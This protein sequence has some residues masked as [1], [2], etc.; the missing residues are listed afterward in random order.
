V[1][2]EKKTKAQLIEELSELRLRLK[3]RGG[4][5]GRKEK[6]PKG[7]PAP[8]GDGI[9]RI[10]QG[11]RIFDELESI[12]GQ[13]LGLQ[14]RPLVRALDRLQT[15]LKKMDQDLK[16][17]QLSEEKYSEIF[18]SSPIWLTISAVKDGRFL[19]VNDTFLKVTGLTRSEVIGKTSV[20]LGFW[21]HPS[22][23]TR[24]MG[25]FKK[26]KPLTNEDIIFNTKTG[27]PHNWLWSAELIKI[28]G[29]AYLI[30][31]A[32][33]ITKKKRMENI[34]RESEERFR[35]LAQISPVGI[36]RTDA[37]GRCIYVNERWSMITG[38]SFNRTQGKK[39]THYLHLDDRRRVTEDWQ[40]ALA[41][42]GFLDTE[43]RFGQQGETV[44]WVLGNIIPEK[45]AAGKG[46]GYVG[47]ITDITPLKRSK[48]ALQQAEL[49]YRKIFE[50]AT[51]GIYQTTPNGRL[52]N[53]NKAAAD[54]LGYENT[55]ELI[56]NSTDIGNQIY[57]NP[58]GRTEAIACL[59][60]D[61]YLKN[62]EVLWRHKEGY[63]VWVSMSTRIVRDARG[64]ALFLEGTCRDISA[65]RKAEEDLKQSEEKL[66]F[67]SNQ[68]IMAQEKER[69]RIAMELHDELGQSLIGLKL[70]LSGFSKKCK[71]ESKNPGNEI[72]QALKQIDGMT[73]NI[74]RITQDL[75][76]TMLEHLGLQEAL[77]WLCDESAKYFKVNIL[78]GLK[79]S[80]YGTFSK[81]QEVIIFRIFQE[82]L[83]NIRK[84]ARAKRVS[85]LITAQGRNALFSI[86]DDGQGFD[87]RVVINRN[88]S[89]I[90][91][92]LT[93][94]D[95]R[96]RMAGGV[97]KIQSQPG[98]GTAITL[99]VPFHEG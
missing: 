51:E 67:L 36:F 66:R 69:K 33:D 91:L 20:E 35:T 19:E 34:M 58:N 32:L 84:H 98:I 76:P 86:K 50:N 1:Q 37:Q 78:N 4:Q 26:N 95:E 47:T 11:Q 68:L 85:I 14:N 99:K 40:K 31:A 7:G 49:N 24:M 73:R 62:H 2:D 72:P 77:R 22:D 94:M 83:N 52:L 70:Q 18:R 27:E 44:T 29:E 16:N 61:G 89:R 87:P 80:S 88:P 97:F 71:G 74:R 38:I 8:R 53:A 45:N 75:H 15:G 23:R 81:E 39:W 25:L 48:E 60:K 59:R 64:K 3:R 63:P 55:E 57:Y 65:R 13:A 10:K 9:R 93:S 17:L 5:G 12:K 82:A 92:G 46:I 28:N 43:Y 79:E 54:I 6:D 96:A 56:K 21:P 90:G 30:S 42:E 41:Q